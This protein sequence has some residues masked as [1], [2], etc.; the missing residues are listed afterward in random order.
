M[1][2]V[3][4]DLTSSG[5]LTVGETFSANEE[6]SGPRTFTEGDNSYEL[7]YYV[8]AT[9]NPYNSEGINPQSENAVEKVPVKGAFIK[10][11]PEENGVFTVAAKTNGGKVTYVTD[12]NGEVI[13]TI[14][15]AESSTSYDILRIPVKAGK[16][17]YVYSGG[18]KI[19]LYYLGFTGDGTPVEPPVEP[20]VV[21]G[22][23]DNS[24]ELNAAD[25][26]ML[27]QKVLTGA[28][29]TLETVKDDFMT[30]LDVDGDGVLTS[31]DVT[32]ILQ[33]SLDSSYKLPVEK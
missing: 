26:A 28:K 9:S 16:S 31:A 1:W 3:E 2:N 23:A 20:T 7:T 27:F 22:D 19:S 32:H 4:E 18:S 33:K 11:T 6:E 10:L 8:Q 30:Y 25:A 29:T 14:G 15:S 5:W 21:Y 13:Q 24:G 12:E 17:Y